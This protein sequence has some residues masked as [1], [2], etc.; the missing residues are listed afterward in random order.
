[1]WGLAGLLAALTASAPILQPPTPPAGGEAASVE[2]VTITA[3]REDPLPGFVDEVA[4][5]SLEGRFEGQIARWNK[6]V[7]PGVLGARTEAADYLVARI[8]EVAREAK[9]PVGR[10]G[11]RPNLIVAVTDQGDRLAQT[12]S[13]T[14]RYRVFGRGRHQELSAFRKA[15]RPVRWWHLSGF[16]V[17][18]GGTPNSGAYTGSA[19][20]LSAGAQGGSATRGPGVSAPTIPSKGTRLSANTQENIT[21]VLVVVDDRFIRGVPARALSAYVAFV[22]LTKL[23]QEPEVNGVSTILNLFKSAEGRLVEQ[24]LTD[25]DRAYLTSL[26]GTKPDLYYGRQRNE[27]ERRMRRELRRAAGG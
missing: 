24:D 9:A 4:V 11:C 20:G 15:S 3:P 12:L 1:M 21:A 8:F 25:Y 18:G 7:C 23:R 26:Y 13:R 16:G 22:G 6:P 2:G 27:M 17:A 14:H 19:P 5:P 10:P